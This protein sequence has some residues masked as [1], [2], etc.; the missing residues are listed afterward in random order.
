MSDRKREQPAEVGGCHAALLS[1][2]FSLQTAPLFVRRIDGLWLLRSWHLMYCGGMWRDLAPSHQSRNELACMQARVWGY[3]VNPPSQSPSSH[4][5]PASLLSGGGSSLSAPPWKRWRTSRRT[6]PS[7][8]EDAATE[9]RVA[10][11]PQRI[12]ADTAVF[13]PFCSVFQ[14]PNSLGFTQAKELQ[15]DPLHQEHE[16]T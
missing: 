13:P 10:S 16:A 12:P 11:D 14:V 9:K 4:I 6:P 5:S 1:M 3:E 2:L 15:E 7:A 8:G